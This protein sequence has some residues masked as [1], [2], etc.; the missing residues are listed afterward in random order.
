MVEDVLL[1]LC[2]QSRELDVY[3]RSCGHFEDGAV[4][5]PTVVRERRGDEGN[6]AAFCGDWFCLHSFK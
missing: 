4:K 2:G 1:N 3:A 5:A 6:C